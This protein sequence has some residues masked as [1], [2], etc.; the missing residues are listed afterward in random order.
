MTPEELK[1]YAAGIREACARTHARWEH[2]QAS[3]DAP[4]D[5]EFW[6]WMNTH[7]YKDLPEL[8][9]VL[10]PM[11]PPEVYRFANMSG[12]W[13][14]LLSGGSTYTMLCN[15]LRAAGK[16][17]NSV[18]SVLDFGS[19]PARGIRLF[20]K[21][22]DTMDIHGCDVDADAI[23]W[24]QA[25]MPYGSYLV[26]SES[27][28]TPYPDNHFDLIYAVSVFSHL[29]E[30]SHHEWLSE[31]GRILAPGGRAVLTVLGE[32]ALGLHVA[33]PK[34]LERGGLGEQAFHTARKAVEAGDFGFIPQ[35]DGHLTTELYGVAFIARNYIEREW[36]KHFDV[37]DYLEAAVD[38]SQDAVILRAKEA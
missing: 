19:G 26:N 3:F 32:H 37:I 38:N 18:G 36:A 9:T 25:N 1:K 14:F 17:W 23:E 5:P 30:G 8:R 28:P 11:P 20:A 16:S 34:L 12:D 24:C 27:L 15:A 21:H 4:Q 22:A 6:V 2:L 13:A 7:G 31:L 10:P 35:P 29:S 33:D